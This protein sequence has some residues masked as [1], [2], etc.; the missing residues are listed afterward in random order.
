MSNRHIDYDKKLSYRILNLDNEK[1]NHTQNDQPEETSSE[2]P[3]IL[4]KFLS[5][6]GNKYKS[7][8]FKKLIGELPTIKKLKIRMPKIYKK[9]S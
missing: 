2:A 7:W 4:S 9:R 3:K 5:L 6:K 8:K 1:I